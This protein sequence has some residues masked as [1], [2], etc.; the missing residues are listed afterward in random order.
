[1]AAAV[2]NQYSAKERTWA[3]AIDKALEQRGKQLGR[4]GALVE[5]AGTLLDKAADG[6]IAALKELGDR[7]DG[8]AAQS[9]AVTGAGGGPVVIQALSGDASL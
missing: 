7:L 1:M 6:D 4:M 9:V 8:K 5:L 2:G 3:T